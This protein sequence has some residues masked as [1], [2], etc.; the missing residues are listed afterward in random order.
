MYEAAIGTTEDGT[1]DPL[2]TFQMLYFTLQHQIFE[3]LVSVD[4]NTQRIIPV[5]AEHWEQRDNLTTRFYLRR[6]V[7]FHNTEPFTAEA[8][9]FTLDLMRDPRNK[10][11]GRFLFDSIAA[12]QVVDDY[13]VDIIL[14]S[15]DALLLRKLAAVGFMFPPHYYNKVGDTYFTRYPV[16]TGPFRFFY[17]TKNKKGGK[18][19]HLVA[20]EDYWGQRP[21]CRELVCDF[22]PPDAQAQALRDGY[23]DM[24]IS[25]DTSLKN[26]VQTRDDLTV[27]AQPSLRSTVCLFNIDKP[28]PLQDIRVRR[29]IEHCINR[30]EIIAK[31]LHGRGRPLYSIAPAGSIAYRQG[32]PYYEENLERAHTLLAEAGF[33]RGLSLKA[34]VSDNVPSAAVAQT[35]REQLSRAGITLNID[36]LTR[37][38]IKKEVVEPKLMGSTQPSRYDIWI[39]NGWPDIFGATAHFYF[40]FL[41]SHGIFNFGIYLNKTSPFD[42]YYAKVLAAPDEKVLAERLYLF[43]RFVMEKAIALPLYQ[44]EL[45][46]GMNK[47]IRFQPGLNDLPLRFKDCAFE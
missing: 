42:R 47:H 39:V 11:G 25:Q 35:L 19:I 27:F 17:N 34:M 43:D 7:R 8:V 45:V 15:P 30:D 24:V 26:E 37:D 12:V 46:Y 4:F 36:F 41:H 18:E 29:A 22:I 13:T 6:G 3:T 5:L 40:L 32:K 9:R 31:P 20:N 16:G 14:R 10:F 28:G 2:R 44:V 33:S 1:L 21:A 23:V 38:R